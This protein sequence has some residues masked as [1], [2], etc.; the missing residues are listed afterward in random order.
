MPAQLFEKYVSGWTNL[1]PGRRSLFDMVAL[2]KAPK[3]FGASRDPNRLVPIVFK[4]ADLMIAVSGDP[5]RTNCYFLSSN[6][7]LGFPTYR[8]VALPSDWSARLRR[9]QG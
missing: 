9:A 4:P 7:M 5:G 3:M 8:K 6:G 2:G 1:I